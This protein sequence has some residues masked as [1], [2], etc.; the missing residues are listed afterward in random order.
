MSVRGLLVQAVTHLR[1]RRPEEARRVLEQALAAGPPPSDAARVASLLGQARLE[2]DDAEG[3]RVALE[4]ALRLARR[5]DPAAL[6]QIR[7]LH[8]RAVAALAARADLDRRRELARAVNEVSLEE[9]LAGVTDA[10]EAIQVLVRKADAALDAGEVVAGVGF[11]REALRQAELRVEQAPRGAV[12]ARLC[13]ARAETP[14]LHVRAA[15]AVADASDD[16]NL[17]TA[18]AHA[19]RAA[20]IVLD[21]HVF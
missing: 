12:L 9:L 20:G 5:A 2:L 18:V 3:A 17:V 10:D 15:A 16:S 14:E 13:L 19:A 4:T 7:L 21:P 1:E 8:G 6:P 11:A